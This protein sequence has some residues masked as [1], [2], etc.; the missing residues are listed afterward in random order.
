M[1]RSSCPYNGHRPHRALHLAP[2]DGG[3]GTPVSH[4]AAASGVRRQ[5]VLGLA[6][7]DWLW[8]CRRARANST[9]RTPTSKVPLPTRRCSDHRPFAESKPVSDTSEFAHPTGRAEEAE[10]CLGAQLHAL[11]VGE[12]RRPWPGP[13]EPS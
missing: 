6:G 10:P 9:S 3:G 12:A 5:D 11:P 8:E 2:P 7:S 4:T 13:K 1:R